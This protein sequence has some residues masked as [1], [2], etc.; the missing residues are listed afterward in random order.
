MSV[1][2]TTGSSTTPVSSNRSTPSSVRVLDFGSSGRKRGRK[3]WPCDGNNGNSASPGSNSNVVVS[4][5]SVVLRDQ[6]TPT[7]ADRVR[8]G[9]AR[10][11]GVGNSPLGSLRPSPSGNGG[12]NKPQ[13]AAPANGGV[14]ERKG[15]SS[16]R[17]NVSEAVTSRVDHVLQTDTQSLEKREQDGSQELKGE[18][19]G[20]D[21]EGEGG[22]GRWE[23]VNNSRNQSRNNSATAVRREGAATQPSTR[24]SAGNLESSNDEECVKEDTRKA[25]QP[26]SSSSSEASPQRDVT[27]SASPPSQVDFLTSRSDDLSLANTDDSEQGLSLEDLA[28]GGAAAQLLLDDDGE[29][30]EEAEEEKWEEQGAE[31]KDKSADL[32]GASMLS[33]GLSQASDKVKE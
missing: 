10:G 5:S 21:E 15:S 32:G 31:L 16:D 33:Q 19:R 18:E 28:S 24:V 7:W 22:G 13:I 17:S 30:E 14:R 1:L 6:T 23:T 4:N 25:G 9:V 29:G 20:E 11:A 27:S 26:S 8:G 12:I 3:V 2:T